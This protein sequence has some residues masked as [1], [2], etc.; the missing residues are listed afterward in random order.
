MEIVEKEDGD[1][2]EQSRIVGEWASAALDAAHLS[3]VAQVR[4]TKLGASLHTFLL[5]WNKNRFKRFFNGF[6]LNGFTSV[7]IH[8]RRWKPVKNR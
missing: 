8:R 4:F 2:V 3:A 1:G 7:F 6:F 5:S